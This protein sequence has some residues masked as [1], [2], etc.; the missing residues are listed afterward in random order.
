MNLSL[1]VLKDEFTFVILNEQL[2]FE[3]LSLTGV[4]LYE[5]DA[6]SDILMIVTLNEYK[7]LLSSRKLYSVIIWSDS[8]EI[9]KNDQIDFLQ[10]ATD[11]SK[12]DLF[13]SIQKIF[14][15]Y[16]RWENALLSEIY[17]KCRIR[18]IMDLGSEIL[19]N[20]IALFDN[21]MTCLA[22]GGKNTIPND[23]LIWSSILKDKHPPLELVPDLK[24][25][26]IYQQAL[27]I[28]K[29]VRFYL[30]SQNKFTLYV[31][32]FSER[33]RIG[34]ISYYELNSVIK[35]RDLIIAS[36]F[37]DLVSV[38]MLREFPTRCVLEGVEQLVSNMINGNVYEI[39]YLS[40]CLKNI[41]WK[42]D[43]SYRVIRFRNRNVKDTDGDAD[44]KYFKKKFDDVCVFSFSRDILM[45]VNEKFSNLE[46]ILQG[47]EITLEKFRMI[48]G[49]SYPIDGIQQIA[50][51][52]FQAS[53]A[54]EYGNVCWEEH[55]YI[56]FSDVFTSCFTFRLKQKKNSVAFVHPAIRKL[57][58][59]DRLNSNNLVETLYIYLSYKCNLNE[60]AKKLF[61]HRNTL[62][63][64]INKITEII[65]EKSWEEDEIVLKF[66]ISC[67]VLNE[68]I[69]PPTMLGRI[70]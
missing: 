35:E 42:V 43:D 45:I 2:N 15:K 54:V 30:P 3:T 46:N 26:H 21:S 36:R 20:P 17:G 66:L 48:G 38:M 6:E 16:Q 55:Y 27:N 10:V 50:R 1:Q 70:E 18:Q 33:K 8:Q 53:M 19:G 58:E 23:D 65:G 7:K 29:S 11:V 25:E 59:Y 51:G 47:L 56:Y 68:N 61:V 22:I 64:R 14:W 34:C 40:H 39:D 44:I 4:Q 62:L 24:D 9:E 60:C 67:R 41:Q 49:I 57:S 13:K 5:K 12:V 63:Y 69:N 37:A 52:Y 31:N 28:K 32:V